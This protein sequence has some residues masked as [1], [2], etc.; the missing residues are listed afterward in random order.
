MIGLQNGWQQVSA[1]R[2]IVEFFITQS[3]SFSTACRLSTLQPLFL[4]PPIFRG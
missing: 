4:Q 1:N 3:V 2:S